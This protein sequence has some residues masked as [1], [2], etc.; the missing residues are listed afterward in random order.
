[1]GVIPRRRIIQNLKEVEV[2]VEDI[3]NEYFRVQD[4]PDTFVQGRSA[5]K[6]IGS[7]LLKASV[8]LK[9]E[10]LDKR[11]DTVY[12]QPVKYG[13]QSSPI[14]PYRYVSVEVYS[15][16]IT[17]PGEAELVIL[18]ELE[19][20]EV[21]FT[22]P[23]R[24]IGTYNVRYRKT[25]NIDTSTIINTQPILFYKKPDVSATATTIAQKKSDPPANAYKSGSGTLYGEVKAGIY[26]HSFPSGSAE[27]NELESTDDGGK[28]DTPAGDIKTE[29]NLWK[30]KTG[31][32][33]KRAILNRRGV[34]EEMMSPGPPQMTLFSTVRNAFNTKMVG[35][36]ID[37]TN[38]QLTPK[39]V[40]RI[41]PKPNM[42]GGG[43][44]MVPSSSAIARNFSG[45]IESVL[46]DYKITVSK[47][48]SAI[49]KVTHP[50]GG[51]QITRNFGIYTH[52]GKLDGYEG[53]DTATGT[54]SDYSASYVDWAVPSTSSYRFDTFIDMDISNMRT[55]SG[56]IYRLKVYGAS[57][58]SQ[59]DFPVLLDTIIESPERLVDNSVEAY[60]LR[61]GYFMDQTHLDKYWDSYGGDNQTATLR[62]YYTMSLADSVY[63]S[64]SYSDFNT[65]GRF[66]LKQKYGFTVKKDV[67]YTLAF[68]A[69]ARKTTKTI[70][71]N[72]D[73]KNY[74]KLMFHLK[75]SE[76]AS[77]DRLDITYSGSFGHSL[78]NA[79]GQKVGLE[80]KSDQPSLYEFPRLS[81][82]FYPK[83]KL[84][85]VKN[86]DTILQMRIEAGEW[87]ISDISLRPAQDT[88][89]SPDEMK[90]R[91]PIEPNTQRPDNFDFLI[92]Y[93]DINGNT[94]EAVTFI[95]NVGISG[96][97]LVVEGDDNMLSGS[98]YLGNVQGSGIEI[99]GGSAYMRSIGYEGFTSASAGGQG[100]FM[101]W[102]G[103]VLPNAPDD[104]SGSGLE[105]HDGITGSAE[106]Y[107]KFR[108]IDS[109]NDG[110]SSFDV[111][112]SRFF[113][114]SV[115]S[116]NYVSGALGNIEITSSNFHLSPT[117]DVTMQGEITAE[118]GGTIGGFTI[119]SDSLTATNF[120]LDTGDKS[121]FTW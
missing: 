31:A 79:V 67:P 71:T 14:L 114:G 12:V 34:S 54:F 17:V 35:G 26:L 94:A 115:E 63:L 119:A 108:T 21:P 116:G 29:T 1:M 95:N 100:G 27:I 3:Q 38:V 120:V 101:I 102:S 118:A 89:F 42:A 103:S 50:Q 110:S 24:F 13:Q 78:T 52:F 92:E 51:K 7:P 33:T 84:D 59:G 15:P 96:S 64:G 16:P 2:F 32:Y 86:T 104:Y 5:F 47:P 75:G 49:K 69:K 60:P 8:P 76:L 61:S 25:V 93:Y 43:A 112:T 36:T 72:G 68:N 98:L 91:V 66:E 57:D 85:R 117:G 83:F 10:M 107:F 11:G 77:D 113:F 46:S 73:V 62:P 81:H 56:D 39:Q 82:T 22:I 6:I 18:G 109:A 9:I 48:Y 23:N 19:E 40:Q 105:I 45:R 20:T 74:A 111:K 55:F 4:V 37:V 30:Y 41:A 90:I 53:F 97:A 121:S 44:G 65:V 80:L 70:N 58:S 106:S 28:S 99:H 88:G 87:Y